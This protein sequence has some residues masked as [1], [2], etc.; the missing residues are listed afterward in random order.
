[1]NVCS[2]T[3][4]SLFQRKGINT[5]NPG[6]LQLNIYYFTQNNLEVNLRTFSFHSRDINWIGQFQGSTKS[7]IIK[8]RKMSAEYA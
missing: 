2:I 1:M 5:K 6:L 4:I 3:N 7:I 8:N